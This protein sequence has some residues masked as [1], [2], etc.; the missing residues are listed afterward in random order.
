M[1]NEWTKITDGLPPIGVPLI[2]TVKDGLQGKL[3]TLRYPV[4][5]EKAKD[6][7][8]YRWSWRFG[9]YDLM[10]GVSEVNGWMEM[11]EPLKEGE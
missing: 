7:C 8:G 10:P 4:Y 1:R 11:P 9:D 3:N 6:G 2:V 5:Y